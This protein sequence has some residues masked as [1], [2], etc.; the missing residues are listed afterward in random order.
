MNRRLTYYLTCCPV[1]R[2]ISCLTCCLPCRLIYCIL[3][4]SLHFPV[5]FQNSA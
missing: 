2:L 5:K 3:Y 1:Y 4:V